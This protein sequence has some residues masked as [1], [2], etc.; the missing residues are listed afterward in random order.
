MGYDTVVAKAYITYRY[1]RELARRSHTT[2]DE[3]LSIIDYTNEE[4]KDEN[5]NKNPRIIPTQRDYIAGAVS[6]YL[7]LHLDI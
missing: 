2:D 3:I 5:S 4:V 6:T 1:R 7:I